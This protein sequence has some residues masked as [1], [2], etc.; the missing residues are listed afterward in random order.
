MD[1][2]FPWL[3][4]FVGAVIPELAAVPPLAQEIISPPVGA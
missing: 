4:V 2:P 3:V 1:I